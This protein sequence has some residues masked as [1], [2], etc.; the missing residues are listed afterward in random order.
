MIDTI[1]HRNLCK[2]EVEQIFEEICESMTFVIEGVAELMKF[3]YQDHDIIVISDSNT[4]QAK[5]FLK[6]HDLDQFVDKVFSQI[7]NLNNNGKL[8]FSELPPKWKGPCQFGGR[9]VCKGQIIIDY[10]KSKNY[11]KIMFTRDGSN[12]YCP[13]MTLSVLKLFSN[14]EEIFSRV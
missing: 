1:N 8:V 4:F 7:L 5:Q 2:I 10:A 14:H 13:A 6:H 11:E 12:D 9:N 3:L